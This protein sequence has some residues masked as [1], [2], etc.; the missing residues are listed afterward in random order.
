[1]STISAS[2][3]AAKVAHRRQAVLEVELDLEVLPEAARGRFSPGR[4]RLFWQVGE[5]TKMALKNAEEVERLQ[6]NSET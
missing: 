4:K 3:E 6:S 5:N 1:M 2:H